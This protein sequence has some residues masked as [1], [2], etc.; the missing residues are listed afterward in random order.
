MVC[1]TQPYGYSMRYFSRRPRSMAGME[2]SSTATLF[3]PGRPKSSAVASLFLPA[4][5]RKDCTR[6]TGGFWLSTSISTRLTDLSEP[7]CAVTVTWAMPV[8]S[9]T[10]TSKYSTCW[11]AFE[12]LVSSEEE[13]LTVSRSSVWMPSLTLPTPS[14]RAITVDGM[15]MVSPTLRV[16]GSVAW[17]ITGW[18]TATSFDVL[19]WALPSVAMTMARSEPMYCGTSTL[20]EAVLPAFSS[21]GPR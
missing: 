6:V 4:S 14:L 5:S 11:P 1:S 12:M 16:L 17:T 19:P 7:A 8:L 21:K 13:P 20:W 15:R 9:P 10:W 2:E 3:V 18:V